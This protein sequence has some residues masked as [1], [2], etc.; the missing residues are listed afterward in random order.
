MP[1]LCGDWGDLSLG[2]DQNYSNLALDC[3]LLFA[4]SS[5]LKGRRQLANRHVHDHATAQYAHTLRRSVIAR[6]LSFG[7]DSANHG[8]TDRQP[9]LTSLLLRFP[10][11]LPRE[12]F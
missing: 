3:L 9:R 6:L 1:T 4:M 11:I 10:E 7:C 5:A 2:S 8:L 12:R